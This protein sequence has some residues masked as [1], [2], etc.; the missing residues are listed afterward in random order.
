MDNRPLIKGEVTKFYEGIT[1]RQEERTGFLIWNSSPLPMQTHELA[2]LKHENDN[3]MESPI[4]GTQDLKAKH[5]VFAMDPSHKRSEFVYFSMEDAKKIQNMF[6]GWLQKAREAKL[7]AA[8]T[9]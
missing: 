6:D 3:V 5:E 8:Q 9:R 2:A 4:V 1:Q 7:L